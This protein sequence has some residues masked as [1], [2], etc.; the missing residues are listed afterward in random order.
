M[1]SYRIAYI[2]ALLDYRPI[3]RCLP[4]LVAAF[5]FAGQVWAQPSAEPTAETV[6]PTDMQRCTDVVTTACLVGE[7]QS[8]LASDID[9]FK[10]Q[11]AMLTLAQAQLA[12]GNV[13][14]AL[15]AYK[16]LEATTARAEFLVS[17]AK[18]LFTDGDN[19]QALE[20]L[21]EAD[22]LLTEGQS[23]LDRL[24]VT[25][26]RQLIAEAFAQAGANEEA[27]AILDDIA[28]YRN[29]IPMNPMLLAL[30]LQLAEDQADIGFRDE[31]A[32]LVRE[33][34]YL[35]LD[36]D[37]QVTP[38]QILRIFE[39]WSSVD[40][41]AA[42]KAAE[43]L[44]EIMSE[45][46]PS[47]F[48]LSIWTGLS[49]GLGASGGEDAT[50][51]EHAQK[52]LTEAPERVAALL[53]APKLADAMRE[54]GETERAVALLDDAHAE[55]SGLSSTMEK[56]SVLLALAEGLIRAEAADQAREVLRELLAMTDDTDAGKM[57]LRQFAS[58]VPAHL[59]LLGRTD[60]AYDLAM[61]SEDG[62]RELA[63]ATAADKLAARGDYLQT[64]RFLREVESEI[65]VMIMAGIAD[66]LAYPSSQPKAQ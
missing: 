32:V 21:R 11:R 30:M 43:E 18:R 57:M 59:A 63:L 53:L 49:L 3:T 4:P 41:T 33:T 28:G 12:D 6:A 54:A 42:T 14:Q 15:A 19:A 56:A 46:D 64:L 24:N 7:I 13:Q 35:V 50:F 10:R 40:A 9:P 47:A 26:Q 2:P 36:Q 23:D 61:E 31:A 66:R 20:R 51:I 34:Y 37:T 48:E 62:N 16:E 5:L 52:S 44:A 17:H 58:L 25:W 39:V 29:R 65:A 60:E 45:N 22:A 1:K 27:R 8:Y 55:A 38:E